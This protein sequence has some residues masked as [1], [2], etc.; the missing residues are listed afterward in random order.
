M[1][2]DEGMSFLPMSYNLNIIIFQEVKAPNFHVISHV[3]V[4][5]RNWY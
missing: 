4:D 5:F 2:E 1:E 3:A